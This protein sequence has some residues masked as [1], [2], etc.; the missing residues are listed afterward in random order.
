MDADLSKLFRHESNLFMP[1]QLM[2]RLYSS[3][4]C[5]GAQNH[6]RDMNCRKA[7]KYRCCRCIRAFDEIIRRYSLISILNTTDYDRGDQMDS[8]NISFEG[9]RNARDLGGLH[10]TDGHI[11]A[12]G[13]LLRS[14]NLAD[15]TDADRV[16]LH[17][18]WH[19][20][21]VIDL[22]PETERSE[23]P[24]VVPENAA[25]LPVPVF[26]GQVEG[27][28]HE[29][30]QGLSQ[31]GVMIPEMESLYRMMVTD[32][33]CRRNLGRAAECVM[34]HDFTKGS[35]LWHCTEGKDRCGLLTAVLLTALCVDRQQIVED[36]MLTNEVNSSRAE[37]YY[38]Q[39]LA[40]GKAEP[41]AVA[42]KNAFLAKTSYISEAFAAM[43]EQYPDMETCL[44]EGLHIS[45]ESIVKFR[46]SVL[47]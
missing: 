18:K 32:E 45:H 1:E 2:R 8:R 20:A 35:V 25:Y 5:P 4:S 28:S 29:K 36:Y 9:I 34:E 44:C 42:V 24:D 16:S 22:R 43:D 10:T 21:R 17:E 19:L 12:S 31:I 38:R 11:I 26:D 40:A 14:A 41:E 23:Q 6:E 39:M 33:S 7:C 13:R 47:L 3:F 30:S 46:K 15:A 37:A 27:I